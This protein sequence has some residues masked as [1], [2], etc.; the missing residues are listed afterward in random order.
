MKRDLEGFA[1]SGNA[2]LEEHPYYNLKVGE[3]C[4]IL[5]SCGVTTS[6]DVAFR[7]LTHVFAIGVETG[8][9]IAKAEQK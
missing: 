2:I 4:D 9:R 6:K 7:L 1:K 3:I 5:D 8:F